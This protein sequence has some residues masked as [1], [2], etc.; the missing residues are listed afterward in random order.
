MSELEPM[1]VRA[2]N[3][4]REQVVTRLHTAFAEGRLDVGELDER[5]AAAYAAKTLGELVPLT[6]DLPE[7][8]RPAGPP[9]AAGRRAA[10]GPARARS[11]GPGLRRPGGRPDQPDRLGRRLGRQTRTWSYFWPVWTDDPAG[12][13]GRRGARPGSVRRGPVAAFCRR[14]RACVHWAVGV[15]AALFSCCGRIGG[16]RPQAVSAGP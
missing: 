10:A 13:R 1:S 4:D 2:G 16:R 9:A 5:L 8:G 3:A 6:A 12:P 7:P 11:L 15:R 14:G